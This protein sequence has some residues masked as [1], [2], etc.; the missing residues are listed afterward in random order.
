MLLYYLKNHMKVD[1]DLYYTEKIFGNFTLTNIQLENT[2]KE[3]DADFVKFT[4]KKNFIAASYFSKLIFIGNNE[5]LTMIGH[6]FEFPVFDVFQSHVNLDY[7]AVVA[8]PITT[9]SYNVIYL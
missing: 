4:S 6:K 7:F 8:H 9:I 5:D 3:N 2:K 1:S